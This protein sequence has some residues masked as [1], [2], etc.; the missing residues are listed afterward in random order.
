[1]WSPIIQCASLKEEVAIGT[2]GQMVVFSAIVKVKAWGQQ[3]VTDVTF[4][5]T[6]TNHKATPVLRK[7]LT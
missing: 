3:A 4:C 1:M 7:H 2:Q 6:K 5:L